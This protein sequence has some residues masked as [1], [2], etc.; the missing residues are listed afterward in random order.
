MLDGI[1]FDSEAEAARWPLLQA[2][3]RAGRIQNLERQKTIAAVI[4]GI[5]VFRYKADFVYMRRGTR[6]VEDVKSS[7][8][9]TLPEY[10]LKMK[11]L[12]ALYGLGIVEIIKEKKRG[13]SKARGARPQVG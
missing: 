9:R 3:Q 11:V 10:R 7:F 4:N 8:T 1:T 13:T 2:E 12:R 6:I 5:V